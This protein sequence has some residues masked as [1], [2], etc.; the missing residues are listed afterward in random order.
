MKKSLIYLL[1]AFILLTVSCTSSKIAEASSYPPP[2]SS[3]EALEFREIWAYVMNGLE[4]EWD[5]NLPVTD[6]GYFSKAITNK[7]EVPDIPPKDKFFS[8]TDKRVH[9]ITSCDSKA[10]TH[11]LLDPSLPLR[12][13]ITDA[14]IKASETYDGLQV[15]W[16]LVMSD[17]AQN[18]IDFL[19]E[20]KAGLKGKTLSI[21]IPARVKT[22]TNDAY[23]YEKLSKTADKIIIMAYDQH[24]STSAPGPVAGTDWCQRI[25]DYAKTQ[26]PPE[27]LIMG[28]SFYGRAWRDDTEGGKAYT[29]PKLQN[30]MQ[31]HKIKKTERDEYLV[32]HFSFTKKMTVTLWFDDS[33]SLLTRTKMYSEKGIQSLSY[34][35][36]GQDDKEYWQYIKIKKEPETTPDS[37]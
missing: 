12:D 2:S 5:E 37:F 3:P 18:Y 36:I 11:L 15:D 17:D 13:K 31:E 22:L 32:P 4:N 7:S 8:G 1:A 14:L 29:Y 6:I 24:W 34:W 19:K 23:N 25:C 30:L 10:Q 26:I 9:L 21:A 27:K 20:L 28:M 35:R 33:L 16:E